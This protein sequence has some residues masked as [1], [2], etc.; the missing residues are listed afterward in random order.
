MKSEKEVSAGAVVFNSEG[1][2]IKYLLLFKKAHAQYQEQWNFPRGWIEDGE[3]LEETA[4]REIREET[5]LTKLRFLEGFEES[6][7]FT[8]RRDKKLISKSVVYF[9]AESDS[10]EITLSFEHDAFGWFSFEKA[11]K[12]LTFENDK[13]VLKKANE[14]F[15]NENLDWYLK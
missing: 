5:G 9:L 6:I 15:D 10:L 14:Y 1:K 13:K 11:L 2:T 3:N 12:K 7:H 8:Y 4:R